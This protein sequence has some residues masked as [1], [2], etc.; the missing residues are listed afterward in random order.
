MSDR[1]EYETCD[2]CGNEIPA[3]EMQQ[4][5][6]CL[7]LCCPACDPPQSRMCNWCADDIAA[8]CEEVPHD[9]P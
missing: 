4:C 5:P 7:D 8:S 1:D 9:Q 6:E 2:H 3:S